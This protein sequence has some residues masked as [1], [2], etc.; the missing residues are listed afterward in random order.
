MH[1]RFPQ[2]IGECEGTA[3][4][5]KWRKDAGQDVMMNILVAKFRVVHSGVA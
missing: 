4:N 5:G 1:R 2:Q 3:K